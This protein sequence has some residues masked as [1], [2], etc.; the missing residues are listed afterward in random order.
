MS[1]KNKKN[2][3]DLITIKTCASKDIVK[4]VK[5]QPTEWDRIFINHVSEKGLISRIYK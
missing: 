2:K 1:K 5:R 3:L 4:Q